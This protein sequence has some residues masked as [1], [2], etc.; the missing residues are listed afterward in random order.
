MK[1]LS[2]LTSCFLLALAGLLAPM[3]GAAQGPLFARVA[4][5]NPGASWVKAVAVGDVDN[6]GQMDIVTANQGTANTVTVLL[7][8]SSGG[9]ARS[10][11]LPSGNGTRDVALADVNG[12]GRLDIFTAAD[13]ASAVGVLLSQAGGGFAPVVL[14]STGLASSPRSLALGDVNGDGWL[15]LVVATGGDIVV[16]PGLAG[17]MFASAV[18]YSTGVGSSPRGLALG[19]LN[20]DGRLDVVTADFASNSAAVLLGQAGGTLGP[21]A[22]FPVAA[23]PTSI[24]LGDLNGDGR[25]DLLVSHDAISSYSVSV[26]YAQ[27]SGGYSLQQYYNDGSSFDVAAAD[28]N[29]DGHLD[30]VAVDPAYHVHVLLWQAPNT[31]SPPTQYT[32]GTFPNDV[33]VADVNGDG[34]PDVVTANNNGGTIGVLLNLTPVPPPVLRSVSPASG[35]VG[36]VVTLTGSYLSRASA[37]QFN[38]AAAAQVTAVSASQLTVVVPAGAISGTVTVTTPSGAATSA[39]TFTVSAP[40]ASAGPRAAML[41]VH[42]NPAR[43]QVRLTVPSVAHE[44]QLFI[45]DAVGRTVAQ[46]LVQPHTSAVVL[47]L[48]GLPVGVYSVQCEAARARLLI[49]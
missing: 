16:M 46:Q 8:Q 17:G 44:R 15:D 4:N 35:P 30:I 24:A 29:G 20:G 43:G 11:Q 36:T 23:E 21:A 33:A 19:D 25:P 34:Q 41:G 48:A 14:Y 28:F 42:P 2:T 45:V 3:T 5:Y 37:V 9:F 26:L 27:A 18:H 38:G 31:F 49:E 10:L 39:G 12:D 40:L 47:S 13:Y 1:T 22:T 7:G 6:D 32:A